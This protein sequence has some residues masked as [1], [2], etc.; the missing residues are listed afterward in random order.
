MKMLCHPHIIRL[1][2][3]GALCSEFSLSLHY[4]FTLDSSVFHRVVPL[5]LRGEVLG[6]SFIFSRSQSTLMRRGQAKNVAN[7]SLFWEITLPLGAGPLPLLY[8]YCLL[9]SFPVEAGCGLPFSKGESNSRPL[10][11]LRACCSPLPAQFPGGLWTC[12]SVLCFLGRWSIAMAHLLLSD[13]CRLFASLAFL[14][15]KQNCQRQNS[16]VLLFTHVFSMVKQNS[17]EVATSQ[18]WAEWWEQGSKK[19]WHLGE[20]L[21]AVLETDGL[22][23]Y[24]LSESLWFKASHNYLQPKSVWELCMNSL[25]LHAIWFLGS[26]RKM[27]AYQSPPRT[28]CCLPGSCRTTCHLLTATAWTGKGGSFHP[29]SGWEVSSSLGRHTHCPESLILGKYYSARD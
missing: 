14:L 4:S 13:V 7:P 5:F 22:L 20:M 16:R 12:W 19:D 24:S 8:G 29:S 27:A 11:G 3:V 2:Q 15:C 26:C 18:K 23:K 25:L 21:N 28:D 17:R 10:A 1:Y 9:F 6:K